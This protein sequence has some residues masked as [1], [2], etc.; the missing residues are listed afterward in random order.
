VI[1]AGY[2]IFTALS[3]GLTLIG[4]LT[5]TV[6]AFVLFGVFFALIDGSQRAFVSDL[7]PAELKG[8]ALGTY[9]TFTGLAA[10]PAGYIAGQLWT[11]VDPSATFLF[12]TVMGIISI[13]VFYLA[14][15]KIKNAKEPG[16]AR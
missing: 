14:L 15:G 13:S 6:I 16:G 2:V 9:H 11:S 5:Y 1:L 4:G 3:L 12:G 10:L 8:T 7:S